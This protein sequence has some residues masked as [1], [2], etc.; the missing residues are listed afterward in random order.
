MQLSHKKV[1]ACWK[2]IPCFR[3]AEG[4]QLSAAKA[5]GLHAEE[6]K[7]NIAYEHNNDENKLWRRQ[8]F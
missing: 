8:S 2:F 6:E 4:S 3:I 7:F 1:V 5:K